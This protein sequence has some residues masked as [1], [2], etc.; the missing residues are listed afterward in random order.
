MA[1]KEHHPNL[2]T[3]NINENGSNSRPSYKTLHIDLAQHSRPSTRTGI[4]PPLPAPRS[5]F[6]NQDQEVHLL[7]RGLLDVTELQKIRYSGLDG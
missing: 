4:S 7:T 1:R 2:K 5:I 3:L 6:G